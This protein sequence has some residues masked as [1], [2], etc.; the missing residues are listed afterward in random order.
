MIVPEVGLCDICHQNPAKHRIKI[1]T[2]FRTIELFV[3]DM[4]YFTK[5]NA[6]ML[7]EYDPGTVTLEMIQK[8]R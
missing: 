2:M 1:E 8:E 4:C 3:C 7:R 5:S 6:Q